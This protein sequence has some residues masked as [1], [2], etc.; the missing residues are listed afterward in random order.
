MLVLSRGRE[1]LCGHV[2][3]ISR[4][5]KRTF[6]CVH[7]AFRVVWVQVSYC[8]AHDETELDLVVHGYAARAQHGAGAGEEDGG[9]GLEKEEGLT[10]GRAR[11][12][13]DVVARRRLEI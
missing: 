4:V 2:K 8:F 7:C 6:N 3:V 1:T 5:K 13:F 9:R 12:L 10:W 11:E